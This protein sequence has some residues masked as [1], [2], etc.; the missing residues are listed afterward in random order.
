M[1]KPTISSNVK[2][3][4]K[5][6]KLV[7]PIV[8]SMFFFA[9]IIGITMNNDLLSLM[10][11]SITTDY[12]C[13]DGYK[14]KGNKCEVSIDA[15]KLGD[16]NYDGV[17][18]NI[19]VSVIND[20]VSSN[21]NISGTELSIA[22]VTGD[23]RLTKE[24]VNKIKFYLAGMSKADI[25]GLVCPT[26]Y[27][28]DGNKCIK[29]EDAVL[30]SNRLEVGSAVYYNDSTWYILDNKDDY[31]TLLKRDYIDT[32]NSMVNYNSVNSVLNNYSSSIIND[33]KEVDGYKIRLITLDELINLG[34]IDKTKTSYYEE[35]SN[36]PYWIGL[37][38]SNYWV[39][40]NNSSFMVVNFENNNYVY[41]TSYNTYAYV[42][43]VVN[44][45]KSALK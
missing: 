21:T 2:V 18:N 22:D 23:G 45:Y 24:D 12:V 13:N 33:L 3:K 6:K 19:D 34:F 7:L 40:N 5:T 29:E 36:T 20:Y 10:G 42:R 39:M 41:E 28:L 16:I 9:V 32:N 4:V 31:V 44:V 27:E 38:D 25:T 1:S 8:A 37:K 17:I 26:D 11:N 14:L 30:V 43:P 15:Y 35:G